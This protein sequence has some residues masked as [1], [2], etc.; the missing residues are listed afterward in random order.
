MSIPGQTDPHLVPS[1]GG[2]PPVLAE[3]ELLDDRD[4][5]LGPIGGASY[6]SFVWRRLRRDHLA[7]AG[8]VVLLLLVMVAFV[9]GP[10]AEHFL[11]HGPNDLIIDG[12][13]ASL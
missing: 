7:I 6:W 1:R 2:D 9:G 13:N 11:G 4:E 10:I 3:D 12:V 8:A 5:R